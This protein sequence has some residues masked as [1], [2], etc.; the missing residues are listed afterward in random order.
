MRR[1]MRSACVERCACA[2]Y[3]CVERRSC[4]DPPV[5]SR[6][7]HKCAF[8]Y[9]DISARIHT[10][11]DAHVSCACVVRCACAD[12]HASKDA[13]AQDTHAS[14]DAHA[15]IHLCTLDIH[16][17]VHSHG[18][19]QIHLYTLDVAQIRLCT[20]RNVAHQTSFCLFRFEL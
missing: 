11:K 18:M 16:T 12:P 3:A 1:K 9:E 2:R 10:H 15:E 13:H 8:V 20:R 6:H 19:A 5:Q 7:T 14:K 4:A 17:N